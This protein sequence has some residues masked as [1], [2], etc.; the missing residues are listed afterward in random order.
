[1]SYATK[2]KAALPKELRDNGLA[3]IRKQL[4]E[5]PMTEHVALVVF[6]TARIIEDVDDLVRTPV[7]RVL[8]IEPETDPDKAAALLARMAELRDERDR[9]QKPMISAEAAAGKGGDMLRNGG[10]LFLAGGTSHG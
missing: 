3:Q 8:R 9:E 5:S 2:M 6:D 1:M 4:L 10:G 7:I